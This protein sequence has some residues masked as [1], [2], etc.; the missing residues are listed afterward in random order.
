MSE[1]VKI[2]VLEVQE[3]SVLIAVEG[4]DVP[5]LL[6]N[7]GD[8]LEITGDA[9]RDLTFTPAQREWPQKKF[10]VR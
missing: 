7:A 4:N 1:T 3:S 9:R 10:R 2:T 5:V 8:V 6:E